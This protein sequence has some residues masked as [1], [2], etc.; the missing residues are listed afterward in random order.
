VTTCMYVQKDLW[1]HEFLVAPT[2]PHNGRHGLQICGCH[3]GKKV[4][5]SM[6]LD[7]RGVIKRMDWL[8]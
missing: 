2:R 4:V 7:N 5:D 3:A 8:G 6:I 1:T